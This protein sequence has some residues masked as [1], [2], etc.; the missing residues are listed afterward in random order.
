MMWH[1]HA[2]MGAGSVWLLLPLVAPENPSLISALILFAVVGSLVPDLD[3]I[4]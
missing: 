4:E 1:T 3:A 2:A